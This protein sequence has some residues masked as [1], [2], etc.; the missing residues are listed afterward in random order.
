MPNT[1]GAISPLRGL[2]LCSLDC[3]DDGS[4]I[5]NAPSMLTPIT[6]KISATP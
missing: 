2:P 3:M 5:S 6:A 4:A 1:N